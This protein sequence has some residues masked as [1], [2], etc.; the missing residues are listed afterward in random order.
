MRKQ[1]AFIAGV[2]L[3]SACAAVAVGSV[4]SSNAMA[5]PA[6]TDKATVDVVSVGDGS[7]DPIS[8]SFDDLSLPGLPLL[9]ATLPGQVI[10]GHA[11]IGEI[12]DSIGASPGSTPLPAGEQ[13]PGV[14]SREVQVTATVGDGDMPVLPSGAVLKPIE[15]ARPGTAEECAAL[16]SELERVTP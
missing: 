5:S 9:G 15:D 11:T 3:A 10:A 16:R 12:I 13:P 2:S 8:C 1:N 7:G 6:A 14:T 4:V